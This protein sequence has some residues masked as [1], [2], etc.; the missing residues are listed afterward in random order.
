M[1]FKTI[2][3]SDM[4]YLAETKIVDKIV[5]S[6]IRKHRNKKT[7]NMGWAI[8][9][10]YEESDPPWAEDIYT[11]GGTLIFRMEQCK[12]LGQLCVKKLTEDKCLYL[13]RGQYGISRLLDIFELELETNV[14]RKYRAIRPH[15]FKQV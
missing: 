11:L 1:F 7:E 6:T 5:Q 14:T 15:S 12:N 2:D 4:I 3:N 10:L 13:T 8:Y 9:T